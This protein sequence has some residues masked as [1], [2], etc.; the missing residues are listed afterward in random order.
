[1]PINNTPNTCSEVMR[2]KIGQLIV[3]YLYTRRYNSSQHHQQ[4]PTEV[5]NE[6]N[7]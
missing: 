2:L 4:L 7:K 1:M 5:F 6:G 3:C